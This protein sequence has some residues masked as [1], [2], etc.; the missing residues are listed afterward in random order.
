MQAFQ[1]GYPDVTIVFTWGI[2]LVH[3]QIGGAV[4]KLPE[5]EYGLLPAFISGM[6]EAASPEVSL[7]DGYEGGY[8]FRDARQ[9]EAAREVF[10]TLVLP[11]IDN[12]EGYRRHFSLGYGIWLDNDW[13]K[14]GW[15]PAE[16]AKNY[17]TPDQFHHTV[18]SALQLSDRYVWIYTEQPRW[19]SEQGTPLNLSE[20]YIQALRDARRDEARA[21]G[22]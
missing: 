13:R 7:V 11:F 8:G 2:S 10:S 18:Q 1:A 9:F 15:N 22:R 6:A 4:S 16:P 5:A 17:F 21:P 20:P 12:A 3:L 14:T 19:W